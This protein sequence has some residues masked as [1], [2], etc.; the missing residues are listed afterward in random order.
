MDGKI[1][2]T[3]LSVPGLTRISYTIGLIHRIR[4]TFHRNGAH[5]AAFNAQSA[6]NTLFFINN[7]CCIPVARG[8]SVP[9]RSVCHLNL[10]LR[11]HRYAIVR[12]NVNTAAAQHARFINKDIVV[13]EQ[14][15]A[16]FFKGVF[17]E[18]PGS[19]SVFKQS[20]SI[21]AQT[22]ACCLGMIS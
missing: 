17:R 11:R 15:S 4:K 2:G 3:D 18:R 12:A 10:I 21:V 14:A 5:R 9:A 13:A 1:V 20:F 7:H 22:S 6:S 19:A 16:G 8:N